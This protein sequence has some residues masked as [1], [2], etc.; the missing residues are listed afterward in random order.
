MD[1]S[2]I[3][4]TFR[5]AEKVSACVAALAR[6]TGAGS[7][8]VLV[9]IDGE[10]PGAANAV[11]A[12]WQGAGGD[13]S[14]LTVREGESAGQAAVR[15]RLLP[16]ARGRTLLFLNDDMVP[17]PGW[18]AAHLDAQRACERTGRPALVVGASPWAPRTPDTLFARLLRETSMVFFYDVMDREPDP[19]HDWGFRH[20]WLLN[21]SAPAALVREVGGF[22]VFPCR[23]GYED[24]ELAFRL[25]QRFGARVL[26]RP[27]ATATHD[28]ALTPGEYLEREYK[29]GYAAL[30]FARAAPECARAMFRRDL[31]A[32]AEAAYA[33][34]FID[35]ERSAAATL[36]ASF[37]KL[38]SIPAGCIE[39][40]ESA[41]LITLLYQQHLPLK[42]WMWRSGLVDA[43]RERPMLPDLPSR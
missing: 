16:L 20:A 36:A 13:P 30:G 41:T 28:H 11:R 1:A 6:Q 26:Y 42:R 43:V 21:L 19:D 31:A 27:Q 37:T 25:Q 35:R 8:E 33:A 22:T 10:D 29:L 15:N 3:I 18:A 38:D 40:T 7:F 34:E 2:V 5:R 14:R 39:G 23:Y 24:D 9:G 4:P 32:P 17:H 12:A